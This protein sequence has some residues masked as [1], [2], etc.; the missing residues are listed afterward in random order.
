[1]PRFRHF[2]S[3]CAILCM[4]TLLGACNTPP[5]STVALPE[6]LFRDHQFKASTEPIRVD[7]LFEV[8]EE[9]R[10][11]IRSQVVPEIKRKSAQR[12]L[13][14]ALYQQGHLRLRYDDSLTRNAAETFSANA[15]NC[16]SL[17]IMTAALAKEMNLIVQYQN[18]ITP[19]NWSRS[20][21]LY[22]ATGHVNIVLGKKRFEQGRSYDQTFWLTI[23]FLPPEDTAGQKTNELEEKTII[24]MY[25]NNRA[26][27][28]LARNQIDQA[29]WWVRAAIEADASFATAFNTLAVIYMRHQDNAAAHIAAQ[30]ARRLAPDNLNILANHIQILTSLGQTQE[31]AV[32]NQLLNKEQP[33]PPFHYF[34]LGLEEMHKRDFHAAKSY[35][36]KELAGAPDYH[37]FHFW[38]GIAYYRLG[39]MKQAQ[40]HLEL[41]KEYSLNRK[42]FALYQAKLDTLKRH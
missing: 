27:E 22:F 14:D 37:E 42:D 26:A 30:H 3:T 4:V 20:G 6:Q 41:A 19:Q 25:M 35:F 16:L 1:M 39:E 36:L 11:F 34:R 40:A 31:A 18:V 8:S 10:Q 7:Q 21:D 15:G 2:I 9:M 13:F 33:I 23:D 32:L 17:V 24:A 12:A 29:Y 28:A 5:K 38:L